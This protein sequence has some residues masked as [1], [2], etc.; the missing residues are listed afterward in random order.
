MAKPPFEYRIIILMF[1][2]GCI[3]ILITTMLNHYFD[4]SVKQSMELT[5][6]LCIPIAVWMASKI[7]DRWHDDQE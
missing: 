4:Y 7:N 2:G 1:V 5:F 3:P 6:I